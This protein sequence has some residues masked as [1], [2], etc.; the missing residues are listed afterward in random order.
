MR[1]ASKAARGRRNLQNP[2]LAKANWLYSP[3][4]VL[5]LYQICRNTLGNWIKEG[6]AHFEKDGRKL[7]RGDA[8]NAFHQSRLE[9]RKRPCGPFE[10]YCVSCGGKHS[11]LEGNI[12]SHAGRSGLVR[13]SMPC[14]ERTGSA[15]RWIDMA[16]WEVLQGL[17]QSNPDS[18]TPD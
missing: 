7:F 13:L 8:L 10:I 12:I 1:D 4:E 5:A 15:S 2:R 3:D 9:N 17:C 6:L 11:L 14:P 18:E 16:H